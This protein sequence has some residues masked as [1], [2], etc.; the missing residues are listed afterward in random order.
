MSQ[1]YLVISFASFPR[2]YKELNKFNCMASEKV[3][4]IE[5]LQHA[6]HNNK[7]N[8]IHCRLAA[9][10]SEAAGWPKSAASTPRVRRRIAMR[11]SGY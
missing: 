3:V 7:L 10:L 8:S 4:A 9:I 5:V 2:S 11:L 6:E 1:Q